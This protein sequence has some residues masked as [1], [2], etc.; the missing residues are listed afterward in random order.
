LRAERELQ[1]GGNANACP[2]DWTQHTINATSPAGTE[3]VRVT[4]A[5]IDG[6]FNVDPQQ[7][8]FFYDFSLMLAGGIDGDFNDDGNYDCLDVDALVGD[9]SA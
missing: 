1:C 2:G 7:S 6:V 4:G 9:I 5:M 8:A 3:F